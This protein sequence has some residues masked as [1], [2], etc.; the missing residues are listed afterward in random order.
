MFTLILFKG[1]EVGR[2]KVEKLFDQYE[3]HLKES[4][5]PF[6][7]NSPTFS[8]IDLNLFP[9]LARIFYLKTSKMSDAH[10][11]LNLDAKYPNIQKWFLAMKNSKEI[12]GKEVMS[13]ESAFIKWVE[14]LSTY[15]PGKKPPL[16]LPVKL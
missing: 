15:P 8:M 10:A 11:E 7:M 1:E 13:Q 2:K 9:H 3:A 6:F 12:N 14:E 5:T 4:N 16:R